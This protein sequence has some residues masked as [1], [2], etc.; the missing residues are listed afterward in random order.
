MSIRLL[1]ILLISSAIGCSRKDPLEIV[2]TKPGLSMSIPF[3]LEDWTVWRGPNGDGKALAVPGLPIQWSETENVVWKAPVPGRGHS[4]PIV[5]GQRVFLTT[6]DEDKQQQSVLAFDRETGVQNG[7]KTDV[8]TGGFCRMH[9]KNSQA[10]ATLA[11]DTE[12]LFAVFLNSDALWMTALDL[13]GKILWQTKLGP[14]QS[15]HGYGSSPVL[16]GNLVIACGDN[17]ANAYLVAV[18]RESGEIVWRTT[19]ERETGESEQEHGNYATPIV[20][21]VAGLDCL[22]LAGFHHVRAY[23]PGSGVELWSCEG[24]AQVAAN[25]VATEGDLVLASAGYPQHEVLCVRGD[26]SKEVLWRHEGDESYVPTPILH[27]GLAYLP[28][29]NGVLVCLKLESGEV[30]YKK[31]LGGN[32]T[33]SAVLSGDRLYLMNEDGVCF[34]VRTGETFERL[35]QNELASPGGM[36]TPTIAGGRIY[37]RTNDSL[38]CIGET[39]PPPAEAQKAEGS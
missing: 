30:V 34:V 38:Y 11:C 31:R 27:K 33:A 29:D 23:E 6:A 16:W 18:D 20:R 7:W 2:A 14:F 9:A 5:V 39:E 10:S 12:R 3:A 15:E 13:E 1:G 24:P 8:H 19:R 21:N 25:G 22:F 17:I 26:G 4:S 37:L 32:F 36:A 35:A 28:N